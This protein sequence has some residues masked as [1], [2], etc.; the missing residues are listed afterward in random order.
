[1]KFRSLLALTVGRLIRGILRLLKRGGTSLPGKLALYIDDGLLEVLSKDWTTV[2]ITGTNGKTLTTA[3]TTQL[4][5][6]KYDTVLTNPSGANMLQGIV[7]TFIGAPSLQ[8]GQEGIAVLEVDEGS[9]K[10]VLRHIPADYLV[11]TNLF[12]DQLDRYG[13]V[14]A[15]YQ[16]LKEA[17]D[18]V[19]EAQLL[20]NADAPL[21]A[22]YEAHKPP[23]YFGSTVSMGEPEV[24]VTC[25][26]CDTPLVYD[27]YMYADLG[28]YHCPQCGFHRPDLTHQLNHIHKLA[29]HNLMFELDH[30]EY[31]LNY[32]GLYNLYN[33]LTA[34]SI[35]R[36]F[37]LTTEQIRDGFAAV[38]PVQGRQE[39]YQLDNTSL[40][41]N[42]FKNT[43]GLDQ[44]IK[45]IALDEKPYDL[46]I[47]YNNH[48]ADGLETDWFEEADFRPLT[49]GHAQRLAAGGLQKSLVAQKL[50]HPN[51]TITFLESPE[52]LVQWAKETDHKVYVLATVTAMGEIQ[53]YLA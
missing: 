28:N 26:L 21:L 3:L 14:D 5:K 47:F 4:L 44:L 52:D 25:P 53:K 24:T 42:I 7:T 37:D 16:L 34:Y 12:E 27:S 36:T 2:I 39:I 33:A 1:M 30:E 17:A 22:Q 29:R 20:I 50:Q 18:S 45:L 23:I 15:I 51:H 6:Q 43:V 46:A 32:G 19:P 11:Q 49:D 9:L 31:T 35:A 41:L 8:S 40:I 48:Y 38:Q 10:H 13:S